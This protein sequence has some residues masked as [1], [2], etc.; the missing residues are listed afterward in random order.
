MLPKAGFPELEEQEV[1]AAVR[2]MLSTV[3]LTADLPAAAP[4]PNDTPAASTSAPVDD[5]TLALSVA[6]ALVSA[7]IG[8]VNIEA[9]NGRVTLKGMLEDAAAVARALKAARATPGVREIEDRLISAEI[10]EHD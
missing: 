2:Y 10:F 8:G 6:D 3:N 1:A 9:R 4:A 5:I 7:K